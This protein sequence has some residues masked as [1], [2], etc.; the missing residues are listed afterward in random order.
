MF[1]P[2]ERFGGIKL[3]LSVFSVYMQLL[4]NYSPLVRPTAHVALSHEF[5]QEEEV[6]PAAAQDHH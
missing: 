1:Q 5:F 3:Y 2:A 4:L 6:L